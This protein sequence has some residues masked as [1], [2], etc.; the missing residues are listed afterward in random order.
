MWMAR[1]Y[2]FLQRSQA[3]APRS[4]SIRRSSTSWLDSYVKLELAHSRLLRPDDADRG[5]RRP[6]AHRAAA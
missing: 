4:P 3:F 2:A 5:R 6:A 1:D